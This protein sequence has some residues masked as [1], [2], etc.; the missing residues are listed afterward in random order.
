[1]HLV[2]VFSPN[3]VLIAA[4]HLNYLL[5]HPYILGRS[6]SKN[7]LPLRFTLDN[8]IT[9]QHRHLFVNICSIE[10]ANTNTLFAGD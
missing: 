10:E 9:M 1:M 6:Q 4:S 2:I 5:F 7:K 8:I 3:S